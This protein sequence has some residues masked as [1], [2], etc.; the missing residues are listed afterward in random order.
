MGS[1]AA[2]EAEAAG[3]I[4]FV[5]TVDRESTRQN[6]RR[7]YAWCADREID[8]QFLGY[9]VINVTDEDITNATLYEYHWQ[10]NCDKKKLLMF[11]L[12]WSA[13]IATVPPH[14]EEKYLIKEK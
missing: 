8:I 7:V 1:P 6:V 14:E 5:T 12:A 4:M 10:I 2:Q 9:F 11:I 3:G 13:K